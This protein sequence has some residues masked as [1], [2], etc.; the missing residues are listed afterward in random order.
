MAKKTWGI[1]LLCF[2][3]LLFIPPKAVAA[4]SGVCGDHLTWEVND[5][6]TLTIKGTGDMYD[7]SG[8]EQFWKNSSSKF[9][10]L[11]IEPGVTNIGHSAFMLCQDLTKV[12]IPE[13]VTR[14]ENGAFAWCKNLSDVTIPNGVVS[15]GRQAFQECKITDLNIPNSMKEIEFA[16]FLYCSELRHIRIPASVTNIGEGA[17]SG[18]TSLIDF[19][20]DENNPAYVAVNGALFNKDQ[21]TLLA[22]AAGRGIVYGVPNSVTKIGGRAF[23]RCGNL[24]N[25]IIPESVTSITGSLAFASCKSLTEIRVADGNPAYSSVKGV[26]F[27]KNQKT[28][29]ACPGGLVGSYI[30]PNS[31]N[32]IG[33]NAFNGCENLTD[34]TMLN[35]V[36]SIG[37]DAF[38]GCS[39]ITKVVIP[40]SVTKSGDSYES[41][42]FR[43]CPNLKDVYYGE[44]EVHWN[45]IE[46]ATPMIADSVTV[47]YSFADVPSNAYY[48]DAVNWAVSQGIT[49]GTTET[50]FSPNNT[51]TTANIITFLWRA[52]GSPEPKTS[53]QFSDVQTGQYYAKAAVW[54]Y[55]NKLVSGKTFN[56]GAPCTR[57][58][59]MQYL[60]ILSGSPSSASNPFSDVSSNAN[61]AQAVAWAVAQGVTNGKTATTFAPDDTCTRGQIVTF[62][63]RYYLR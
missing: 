52:N 50:T 20:V 39:S 7:Y 26:L 41:N 57:A 17:L 30:V 2:L 59:T 53:N 62:L 18:C 4:D 23:E 15:I 29:L 54:A 21:T 8:K 11:V 19:D 9:N 13:S 51:C 3:A 25:I 28:L 34:V 14:I 24:T 55:E 56:G 16:S 22:F 42:A 10:T 49:N 1:V 32:T 48:A 44:D 63:L 46:S 40:G 5:A 6:G 36:T 43:N 27:D 61:Y 47:H 33:G 58:A 45:A 35:G 37:R 12:T 31:V 60:W 38:S